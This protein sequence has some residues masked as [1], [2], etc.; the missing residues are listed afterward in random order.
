MKK[1][2]LAVLATAL[3]LTGCFQTAQAANY[4]TPSYRVGGNSNV[5]VNQRVNVDV[6]APQGETG[7]QGVQG[8]T[9]SVG[10]TGNTGAT[11]SAGYNGTDGVDGSDGESYSRRQFSAGMASISAMTNIPGLSNRSTGDTGVGVGLGSFNGT[12]AF[13]VGVVHQSGEWNFKATAGRARHDSST[14]FGLGATL[15]F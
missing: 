14:A 9:G 3:L 1:M 8:E 4:Q 5:D 15:A 12:G 2:I 13:A 11:G 7:E 6:Y 10:A